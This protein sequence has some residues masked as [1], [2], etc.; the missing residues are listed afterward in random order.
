MK[1]SIFVTL[2]SASSSSSFSTVSS[3]ILFIL[4]QSH[5]HH[6]HHPPS[7][8]SSTSF[9]II[10]LLPLHFSFSYSL[11]L[12]I[13]IPIFLFFYSSFFLTFPFSSAQYP[14]LSLSSSSFVF[15]FASSSHSI[16]FFILTLT[17]VRSGSQR[18]MTLYDS[19]CT[20]NSGKDT[21]GPFDMCQSAY[22]FLASK[23]ILPTYHLTQPSPCKSEPHN[24][25]REK[26]LYRRFVGCGYSADDGWLASCPSPNSVH[27]IILIEPHDGWFVDS[28]FME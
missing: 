18:V 9:I 26:H 8:P 25:T 6:H 3:L 23:A 4:L 1:N 5:H 13:V 7:S 27:N 12:L 24:A 15:I 2:S 10:I 14:F 11:F 28:Q 22:L 17:T 19:V 16:F 21:A 20:R